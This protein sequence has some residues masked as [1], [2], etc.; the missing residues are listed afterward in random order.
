MSRT[1]NAKRLA[2]RYASQREVQRLQQELELILDEGDDLLTEARGFGLKTAARMP[3]AEAVAVLE[4]LEA[5]LEKL[6]TY[7]KSL[8]TSIRRAPEDDQEPLQQL[9]DIAQ[10]RFRI[11]RVNGH[12]A[13][14]ALEH[15][16]RH[17]TV[18]KL[19]VGHERLEQFAKTRWPVWSLFKVTRQPAKYVEDA[20]GGYGTATIKVSGLTW[21][22]G[23]VVIELGF[24]AIDGEM[25]GS[26]TSDDG[27]TNVFRKNGGKW[28]LKTLLDA[29]GKK[30]GR[31]TGSC[32]MSF[33]PNVSA[34][35]LAWANQDYPHLKVDVTTTPSRTGGGWK[36]LV[37]GSVVGD[38]AISGYTG[39][40][41]I[42]WYTIG[43][44]S[45]KY[46][47]YI[48]SQCPPSID[49]PKLWRQLKTYLSKKFEGVKPP[50]YEAP[51]WK[52]DWREVLGASYFVQEQQS[53]EDMHG[54]WVAGISFGMD[55]GV[56]ITPEG[57]GGAFGAWGYWPEPFRTK[58]KAK[59]A[60]D[61]LVQEAVD[62][63]NRRR[64]L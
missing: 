19:Q 11:M 40:G 64:A 34:F 20:R 47:L 53:R 24:R 21:D 22:D 39:W 16:K 7:I 33:I 13:Q 15:Y 35:V 26:F 12:K 9:L 55:R 63:E 50:Q 38:M 52:G 62:K 23:D 6:Q 58:A 3:V 27:T 49:E 44:D 28:P 1:P 48:H 18:G 46:D 57:R 61:K 25:W 59:A 4:G 32:E 51:P 60:I 56:W 54:G 5:N 29:M 36:F 45:Y 41:N 2:V 14:E 42:G 37:D 43:G 30:W 31:L 10:K 8:S 17:T